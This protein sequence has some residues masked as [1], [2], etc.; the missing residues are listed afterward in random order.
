MGG[1]KR[2]SKRDVDLYGLLEGVLTLSECAQLCEC[3]DR[4]VDDNHARGLQSSTYA[5]VHMLHLEEPAKKLAECIIRRVLPR[6]GRELGILPSSISGDAAGHVSIGLMPGLQ[7]QQHVAFQFS[8]REPAINRYAFEPEVHG[9]LCGLAQDPHTDGMALTVLVALDDCFDGGGTRFWPRGT[10]RGGADESSAIVVR[11]P[12]GTAV[13]FG[14]D[15][16][17]CGAPLHG[18]VR[19]VFVASFTCSSTVLPRGQKQVPPS[20]E[21]TFASWLGGCI[22]RSC[23]TRGRQRSLTFTSEAF[24]EASEQAQ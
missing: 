23:R 7:P 2:R 21:G 17:H 12:P 16:L 15:V 4:W 10:S 9:K 13:V 3:C 22:R 20:A 18:G 11:A 8:G 6:A 1:Y 14:G 5:R 24:W 19:H